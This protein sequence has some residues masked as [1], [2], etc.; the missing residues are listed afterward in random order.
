VSIRDDRRARRRSE[1]PVPIDTDSYADYGLAERDARRGV[2]AP[3]QRRRNSRGSGGG[4]SGLW[5]LV[6]F[7]VFAVVLGAVVLGVLLTVLRPVARVAVVGWAYD[8]ASALRIPFVADLVREDLGDSLKLPAS[9]D[10]AIVEFNV[11]AGDTPLTLAT[12]LKAQGL[13]RDERAF[14]FLAVERNL[15]SRLREGTFLLRANMTPEQVVTGVVDNRLVIRTLAVTFREGLRIE[16]MTAK[17]QTI[18][19]AVDPKAFYD[20][21]Q[22]PTAELLGAYPWLNLPEGRSLEGYLYPATYTLTV[23]GGTRRPPTTAM[24]LVKAMLDK[25][26]SVAANLLEVPA[27]RGLSFFQVLTLASIVEREAVLDEE[28]PLIAGVYQNRLNGYKGIAKILNADPT[29]IYAV[30]TMAL[31]KL[32]FEEWK[33]YSFWN[34]P[35]TPMGSVEVTP[36]LVG[37]QTYRSAGLIPGPIVSPSLASIQAA[38]NPDT[39]AGYLFFLAIPDRSGAHVFS[40]TQAEHDA[41]KRKYGYP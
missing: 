32:P 16:Q 23:D 18:E 26:H 9:T 24:D 37:Y 29:V 21:A 40:K 10:P 1:Q 28:R 3:V 5:G 2:Y 7:L 15:A 19:S 30:D 33:T 25:F 36:E 35:G 4:G 34:V 22:N 6:R 38:L 27:E 17:L 8:N 41:N 12:R 11:V 20:L 31:A 13:I 14:I 39:G